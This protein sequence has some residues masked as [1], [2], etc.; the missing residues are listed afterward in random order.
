[1]LHSFLYI[2]FLFYNFSEPRT[3]IVGKKELYVDYASSL[4]ITCLIKSPNPPAYVFWKKEGKV[5]CKKLFVLVHQLLSIIFG[6]YL[7]VKVSAY[8]T[9][10]LLEIYKC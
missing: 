4:N 6:K 7:N 1:M 5:S 9:N 8:R 3:E 2:Y 10:A